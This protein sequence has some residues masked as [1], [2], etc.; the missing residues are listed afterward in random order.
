V[1]VKNIAKNLALFL[2]NQENREMLKMEI[3]NSDKVEH[4]L[5]ASE[6]L[7]KKQIINTKAV[8]LRNKLA[9]Y[10]PKNDRASFCSE[11]KE[12]KFGEFDIYFPLNKW[13]HDWKSNDKLLIAAIGD[14]RDNDKS[15]ILAYNLNGEKVYLSSN[16]TPKIPTLVICR[17]EKREHYSKPT[18]STILPTRPVG[19]PPPPP[20]PSKS[21]Y[22]QFRCDKFKI[23]KDYD[24]HWW[25]GNMEIYFKISHRI[26]GTS[27]W[28]GWQKINMWGDY[29]AGDWKIYY[30]GKLLYESTNSNV[31]IRLEIW[32]EDTSSPDDKVADYTWDVRTP[33]WGYTGLEII[34]LGWGRSGYNEYFLED[35]AGFDDIDNVAIY[36]NE[37]LHY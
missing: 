31:E 15:E 10:L 13:R 35:F 37:N 4:I 2:H 18:H 34:A 16:E 5:E 25:L 32:E 30:P 6:F 23:T 29:T 9:S 20:P 27:S 7:N 14:R 12:L 1:L 36:Y 17:S 22:F 11:I 8:L 33:S 21:N 3:D 24:D 28:S 26:I 19:D